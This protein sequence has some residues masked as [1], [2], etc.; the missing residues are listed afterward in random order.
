MLMLPLRV[1][2]SNSYGKSMYQL[3]KIAM[4]QD[5]VSYIDIALFLLGIKCFCWDMYVVINC[6]DY[7]NC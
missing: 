4:L 6:K 5:F 3:V 1:E 2:V 7:G